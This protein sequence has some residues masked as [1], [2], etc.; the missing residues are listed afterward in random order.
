VVLAAALVLALGRPARNIVHPLLAQPI[1]DLLI[2]LPECHAL[3]GRG[4]RVQGDWAGNE[5]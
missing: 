4:G 3:A 2:D 5:G 1:A